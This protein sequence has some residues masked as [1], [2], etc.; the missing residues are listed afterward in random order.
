[1]NHYYKTMLKVG[2]EF[3]GL[4]DKGEKHK[5]L[6]SALVAVRDF[7][8]TKQQGVI[9]KV[10][11]ETEDSNIVYVTEPYRRIEVQK[12]QPKSIMFHGQELK[13]GDI[14]IHNSDIPMNLTKE[15]TEYDYRTGD[16]KFNSL[17]LLRLDIR[18][19]IDMYISKREPISD[20]MHYTNFN[21]E[22]NP[23]AQKWSKE[24]VDNK[25]FVTK[26]YSDAITFEARKLVGGTPSHTRQTGEVGRPV[27]RPFGDIDF[28]NFDVVHHPIGVK[29]KK[30]RITKKGNPILF[31]K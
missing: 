8:F 30:Y 16:Y 28:V 18:N 4:T 22:G 17:Q 21:R 27:R 31:M 9:L 24:I 11:Q 20:L 15:R 26:I 7:H 19:D 2:T 25:F 10:D 3:R 23:E 13:V 12:G 1:M 14:Y 5:D 6:N 29:T